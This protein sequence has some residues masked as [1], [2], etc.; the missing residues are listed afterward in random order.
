MDKELDKEHQPDVM[1][2]LLTGGQARCLLT[3]GHAEAHRNG[4]GAGARPAWRHGVS[5]NRLSLLTGGQAEAR[6]HGQGAGHEAVEHQPDVMTCVLT[7]GQDRCL[8]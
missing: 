7:G 3:G 5:V 1:T 2:Y 4:Q 6:R 8:L